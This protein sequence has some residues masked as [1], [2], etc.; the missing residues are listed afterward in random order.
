MLA[1]ATRGDA[2]ERV[3][4]CCHMPLRRHYFRYATPPPDD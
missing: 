1:I 2:E 4:C 3:Y